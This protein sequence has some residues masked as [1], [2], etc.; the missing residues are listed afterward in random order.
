MDISAASKIDPV[1]SNIRAAN[2]RNL[3]VAIT[4]E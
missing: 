2:Y 1:L 3:R 4:V